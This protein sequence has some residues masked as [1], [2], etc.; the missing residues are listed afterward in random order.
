MLHENGTYTFTEQEM[1]DHNAKI[2]SEFLEWAINE[3]YEQYAGSDTWLG[4]GRKV[5]ST[6][7][8]F[9]KFNVSTKK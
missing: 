1:K 5:Y 6:K 2:A 3:E 9:D 7:Q 8:L 4:A